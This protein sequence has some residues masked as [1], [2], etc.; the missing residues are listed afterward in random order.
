MRKIASLAMLM[1]FSALAFAQ[2][3]SVT[4]KVT[5]EQGIAVPLASVTIK[6]T[7]Q[8][9]I[10]DQAGTFFIKVKTGDVLVISSQGFSTKEI[11]VGAGNAVSVTLDKTSENLVEVIVSSGYNTKKTQRSLTS[12]AQ[13]V[14]AEQLNTIRQPNIN[15]AIAGKVAGA[16]VRSQSTAALG[17]DAAIRLRGDG[18]LGGQSLLYIVDG[19]PTNSVDINPDDVEDLT[20]LNG[21]SGAAIYGPQAADGAIVI[22]TKRAKK[23]QKGIGIEVN[24]GVTVDK[25]YI[26][27]NY[28]NEYAGGGV[29][30]LIQY[31]WVA[32]QPEAWK[33]LD[34]KFYHDYTDDASWGPRM[35]G[36]EYIP[37]YAW[38]PGTQYSYKTTS[39]VPQ[40]DNVRDF[41]NTGI[42]TTNNINFS[43]AGDNYSTR[44]SYTNLDIQ[45]LIPNTYLKRNTFAA[46]FS[47]DLGTHLTIATN[48]NYVTQNQQAENNDGYS[49]MSSGSFNQ[50]FHRDLDTKILKELKGV[51]SPDGAT[52]TPG[53]VGAWNHSNPGSYN[54]NNP[55]NFYG[56]NYWYN[57]FTYFDNQENLFRRDRLFGD[58]SLTYK[59]NSDFK[60]RG[61]YRKSLVNTWGE[62]RTYYLLERSARQTG[63]KA[64]Y[65]TS[66]SYFTDDRYEMIGTYNKKINDFGIDVLA[67]GEIVKISS[68]GINANTRDGLYIPDFFALN[69]SLSPIAYGNSRSEEKRRAV[70]TRLSG[71][72]KNMIF[73]DATLRNDWYS[74]LPADDNSIFVKSFGAG[75]VFSDLTKSSLP[76]LSYG[77]LRG[78]WGEVPQ[79][80]SPYNLALA[81]SIG[82]DQWAQSSGTTTTNYFVQGT[83]NG[84]VSSSIRGATQTTK[85]L[86]I[87]LR[88][89]RNRVG[90][91]ATYYNATTENSPISVTVSGTS[92]FSSQ[93]INAGEITRKG[94]E[95]QGFVRPVN[96]K[97]FS[98]E[99]SATYANIID[100]KVVSLAPGVSQITL[101]SGAGFNGITP[102]FTV[103]Q[104]GQTWGML[105]G[106]GKTYIDGKPVLDEDGNYVKSENVKFGSVLPDYTGGVQN[107]FTYKNIVLN[108]NI[109]F[110]VGGK[111]FSMSDMW[112]SYSGLTA[113]TA[114]LNDRGKPIRDA[115]ADGGGIHMVG[116][117]ADKNPIDMYVEASDYFHNMVG[118]NVFDEFIYDLSYVKMREV[119]LGYRLPVQKWGFT[120]KWLQNATFSVIA[121]NPWM[122]YRKSKDFD[123]SEIS[124]VFG[125]N[126]Q[127]PGTR[128]LGVNLK[129]GF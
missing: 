81:Y 120:S 117:D 1:L 118:N 98:W 8:G 69:N 53:V 24:S 65:S 90:I 11:T 84:L 5:D 126:G 104:E 102:P 86:G 77:K 83:P 70:F 101:S 13:V 28:Q 3:R 7:N 17:R 62:N 124:N 92:G 12:N 2:T 45:G 43:K 80:I 50:W 35:E 109:D 41:Y 54:A 42:T 19:T 127:F 99:L 32:G 44:I 115:V 38:Y 123:P 100:N 95:L 23:G 113:R 67:G 73:L 22:T 26:L 128:S 30:N 106:G 27:P 57:P 94:I 10:A 121:R 119:S 105:I 78:A 31:K 129:L 125:E 29:S 34:G 116:V 87:D 46:N 40:K 88:F 112:G 15:N 85:E 82:A 111:F 72:W 91:S 36:Q 103:H 37:W 39:L 49:N 60:L 89:L 108:I 21:P 58:V 52:G 107:S 51:T 71:S 93:T 59:I 14:N 33:A 114:G 6:G 18:T 20:V 110:Q 68:K 79:A 47:V 61:T 25:V 122:I 9:A 4:G 97:D 48:L 63:T 16:Q 66:E 76:W 96:T 55:V 56:A 75:F 64:G 74:T